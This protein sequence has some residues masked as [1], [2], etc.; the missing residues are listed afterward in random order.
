MAL[1]FLTSDGK[2]LL[3]AFDARIAQ[4]EPK[5]KVTT[6]ERLV[7]NKVVY[8]M[9]KADDWSREAYFKPVVKTDRLT[10]NI[11]KP[12]NKN[13]SNVAYGYYHGHLTETF[14]NHFD[15]LF[16]YATSS[17]TGEMGDVLS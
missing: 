15:K 7:H 11:V 6:W 2:G 9:H 10:F 14:L 3:A 16:T 8:Y 17:A 13:L 5:G 4:T 1:H 12:D